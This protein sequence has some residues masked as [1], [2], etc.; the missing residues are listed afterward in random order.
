[1]VRAGTLERLVER[2][3]FESFPDVEF[4][5]AFLL[6]YRSFTSADVLMDLLAQVRFLLMAAAA[7]LV[8][9]GVVGCCCCAVVVRQARV[10]VCVLG[11]GVPDVLLL[12]LHRR[13]VEIGCWL[14][15]FRYVISLI[16]SL[17]SPDPPLPFLFATPPHPRPPPCC[18]GSK[19]SRRR[20]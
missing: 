1:M 18:S 13:Q 19:S 7:C 20:G 16:S 12:L 3:T 9:V 15:G 11:G 10:C 17:H 6:T 2:L 5:Q 14:Y 8:V 4:L